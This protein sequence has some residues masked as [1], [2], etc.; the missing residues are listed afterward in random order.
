MDPG[1]AVTVMQALSALTGSTFNYNL[2]EWG[3]PAN[4]QAIARFQVWLSAHPSMQ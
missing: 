4:A 2:H 3:P 1:Q